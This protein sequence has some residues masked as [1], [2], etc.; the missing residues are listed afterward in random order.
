MA[1]VKFV[2]KSLK[3][4]DPPLLKTAALPPIDAPLDPGDESYI[5]A[6]TRRMRAA[7]D[8]E[9]ADANIRKLELGKARGDLVQ[10]KD[11][12]LSIEL[13]HRQ[14]VDALDLIPSNVIRNLGPVGMDFKDKVRTSLEEELN[15]LREGLAD[16]LHR[17]R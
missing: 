9:E 12:R 4:A 3:K 1:K 11:V 13:I 16:G 14:W 8:K 10:L 2:P 7:A 17:K 5:A 6:Q 15:K